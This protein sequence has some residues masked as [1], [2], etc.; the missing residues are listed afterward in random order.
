MNTFLCPNSIGG[1]LYSS[2]RAFYPLFTPH[3]KI[4]GFPTWGAVSSA[5]KP[6]MAQRISYNVSQVYLHGLYWF[7]PNQTP[8]ELMLA[9][10]NPTSGWGVH[11][12]RKIG[13]LPAHCWGPIPLILCLVHLKIWCY[14]TRC[15]LGQCQFSL[16]LPTWRNISLRLIQ[17]LVSVPIFFIVVN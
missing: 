9:I 16:D 10:F 3:V 8:I 17:V 5:Y 14:L 12:T 13:Q 4:L 15:S 2:M 11:I 7:D 1:L 6:S